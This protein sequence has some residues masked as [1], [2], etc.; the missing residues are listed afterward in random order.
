MQER[1]LHNFLGGLNKDDSPQILSPGDYTEAFNMRTGS[2]SEE[3]Q[4]GPA[5]T[6]QSEVQILLNVNADITYYGAAIGGRFLYSG[7][8]EVT[9]G[10]KTWMKRNWDAAYPGSKVYDDDETNRGIYGGL[11]TWD[12]IMSSDFCPD[13]WHVPSEAEIDTLLTY[14]GGAMLAGGHLKE[15]GDSHWGDPNT[16]ADD[17]YGFRALPGGK[18]DSIFELLGANEFLWLK[19]EKT[20][21]ASAWFL[22]SMDELRLMYQ[23]LYL[24]GLGGFISSFYWSSSEYDAW[25]AEWIR[26]DTGAEFPPSVDPVTK[27]NGLYV[28][29]CH[30]FIGDVGE[31]SIGDVG[32]G[33]GLIFYVSGT[34]YYEAAP[35][36]IS[37]TSAWSNVV[38]GLIGT[39]GTAIGTGLANTLAIIAQPG[40]TNSAAKLCHDLP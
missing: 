40:H 18:F 33:G 24:N 31:F 34:T 7:Y 12:Q 1:D 13:G 10:T 28:R 20:F 16:G 39:T 11:Y 4:S 8:Q 2:S 21:T 19:D 22:P 35:T 23:N 17:S 14:L 36:D 25:K 30:T 37:G 15:V 9:I 27:G 26:F 38:P 5:E 32:P 29:A 6:L 3:N